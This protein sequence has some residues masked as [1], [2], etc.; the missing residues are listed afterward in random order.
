[1]LATSGSNLKTCSRAIHLAVRQNDFCDAADHG[2]EVEDIPG[3][4]EIVLP[5]E[6]THEGIRKR[7]ERKPGRKEKLGKR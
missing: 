5:R 3:V 7:R 6:F 2:D 4:S 1:M